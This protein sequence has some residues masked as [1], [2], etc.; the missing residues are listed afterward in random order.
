MQLFKNDSY[1]ALL[2]KYHSLLTDDSA[3]NTE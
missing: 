2:V 1:S 3:L